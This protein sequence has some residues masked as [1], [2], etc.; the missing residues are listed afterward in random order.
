M[1]N[2]NQFLDQKLI[3]MSATICYNLPKRQEIKAIY[4]VRINKS[5]ATL[6]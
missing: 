6:D 2:I 4:E 5:L 1:K 3:F